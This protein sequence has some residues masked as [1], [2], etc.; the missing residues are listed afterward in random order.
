MIGYL[1]DVCFVSLGQRCPSDLND[2]GV[3]RRLLVG[4][5][6]GPLIR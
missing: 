4:L 3:N 6:V 2:E 1:V 5:V